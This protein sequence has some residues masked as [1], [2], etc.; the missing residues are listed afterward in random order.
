MATIPQITTTTGPEDKNGT[1]AAPPLHFELNTNPDPVRVS[2]ATGDPSRVDFV[3]VGSRRSLL[4]VDCRKI[5][6]NVPTGPNSPDLT[7]DLNSATPQISLPGWTAIT[8]TSTKTVTFTP[9]SGHATIGR[10]EGVTLQLMGLRINTV[11][12]SSP[13][14]I[15]VEWSDSG[16]D[17][18]S[19]DSLTIDVGK[20]PADFVLRNFIPE[21]LVVDNGGSVKLNWESSGASSLKLLYDVAEV[22]VLNQSTY[23]VNDV[24]HSTVFYLRATVQAGTGTVE[25]ILST[26]VTVPVPDL[27]VARLVVNGTI[28]AKGDVTV[29]TGKALTVNGLLAAKGAVEI[30]RDRQAIIL[31][32]GNKTK[33]FT[34]GTDGWIVGV[35]HNAQSY[36]ESLTVRIDGEPTVV[37]SDP[38]RT[39]KLSVTLP[40]R[41]GSRVQLE[42]D[43][44]GGSGPYPTTATVNWHPLGD[45]SPV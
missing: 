41:R 21:R 29:A 37:R 23:T 25:R 12:G 4:A 13:L 1:E 18:W 43:T 7:S 33:E 17:Y 40:V 5:V 6:L 38:S 42:V 11:V 28:E 31:N 16:E 3:L 2:P 14:R 27:E 26:Q 34:A 15:D 24:R 19:T 22:N 44:R 36:P 32:G 10:D 9:A 30:Q 39:D 8:N 35:L 20:F 45:S